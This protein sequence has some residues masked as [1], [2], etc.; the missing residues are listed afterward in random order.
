MDLLLDRVDVLF[1][2]DQ[3]AC[4]MAGTTDV[5][6]AIAQL[7]LQVATVVVTRG[8]HGST[9]ASGGSVIS[10]P[11]ASVAQ[12]VDTTGAGDMFAAGFL[13]GY[14][15][16]LG[17]ERSAVLGGAVAAEVVSHLGARPVVSL[18]ELAADLL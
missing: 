16:G 11:A 6:Q 15:H 10:V 8:A 12:V 13:Y 14:T 18:R 2:N 1:A 17:I 9:V 4:G 3:E 7:S 5:D